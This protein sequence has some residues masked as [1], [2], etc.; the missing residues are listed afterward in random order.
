MPP[1]LDIPCD[2]QTNIKE[3][4]PNLFQVKRK[5][6]EYV[7]YT[8]DMIRNRCECFPGKD[9]STCCYQYCLWSKGFSS[10]FNFL[11]KFDTYNW[12]K[13]RNLTICSGSYNNNTLKIPHS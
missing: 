10:S 9:G 3:V 4:V 2:I 13:F 12:E 5:T 8:V 11:P 6:K 1:L 7:V